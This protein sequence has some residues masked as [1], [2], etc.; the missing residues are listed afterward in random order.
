[1]IKISSFYPFQNLLRVTHEFYDDKV[2]VKTKSLNSEQEFDFDYKDVTEISDSFHSNYHQTDFGFWLLLVSA[3]LIALFCRPIYANPI[4]LLLGQIFYLSGIFLYFAGFKKSWWFYFSDSGSNTI[5]FIK[6]TSKNRSKISQAIDLIKS[7]S[8]AVVEISTV[9]PFPEDKALFEHKYY[10]YSYFLQ[11]T[12]KFYEDEI[13]GYQ[14][15]FFEESVYRISYS[16]LT[17]KIH[18]AKR[19]IELW[20]WTLTFA[21]LVSGIIV[22]FHFAFGIKFGM[23]FSQNYLYL[24]YALYG[25]F[26]AS[27]P[28]GLIKRE[29]IGLYDKS[30]KVAY[31]TFVSKSEKE[32][33]EKIIE[34]IRSKVSSEEKK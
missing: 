16:R 28:F 4:L 11:S 23:T 12:D 15:G 33:V 1:M 24:F 25:I 7:K 21:T 2:C 3:F 6:Q 20:G 27:L 31:W 9:D 18:R 14:K 22:G 19:R 13:I 10:H 29:V 32:K 26:L 34:F 8:D 30:G 17:G 5:S